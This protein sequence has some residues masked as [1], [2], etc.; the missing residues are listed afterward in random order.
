MARRDIEN[1]NNNHNLCEDRFLFSFSSFF[2]F[3]RIILQI[4]YS[5]GAFCCLFAC[6]LFFPCFLII[7]FFRY[8]S[9]LSFLFLLFFCLLAFLPCCVFI[10][11]CLSLLVVRTRRGWCEQQP[12]W[13]SQTARTHAHPS[14]LHRGRR[15]HDAID[16]HQQ[17][18]LLWPPSIAPSI[19]FMVVPLNSVVVIVGHGSRTTRCRQGSGGGG[20][21]ECCSGRRRLCDA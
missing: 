6:H 19:H 13:C 15:S 4:K 11:C 5:C 8:F 9:L 10:G 12:G 2:F 7:I 17:N 18:S 14:L 16:T 20:G 1:A 3:I 21:G